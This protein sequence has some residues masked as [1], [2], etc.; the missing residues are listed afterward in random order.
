MYSLTCLRAMDAAS[1]RRCTRRLR[2]ER[3]VL[4]LQPGQCLGLRVHTKRALVGYQGC[5]RAGFALLA[6][7]GQTRRLW[8]FAPQPG[9]QLARRAA[10]GWLHARRAQLVFGRVA[11]PAWSRRAS[12]CVAGRGVGAARQACQDYS[13]LCT[14]TTVGS[15]SPRMAN[16]CGWRWRG[17]RVSVACLAG[18]SGLRV[19]PHRIKKP[20]TQSI[21]LTSPQTG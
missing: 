19:L 7:D 14:T 11:A 6:P 3:G 12:R 10:L 1:A 8:G 2:S 17:G 16:S 4:A 18:A 20:G 15:R 13:L 21:S 9:T 5:E